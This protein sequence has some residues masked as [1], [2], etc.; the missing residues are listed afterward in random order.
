MITSRWKGP[1]LQP[2]GAPRSSTVFF[3]GMYEK[4]SYV[5]DEVSLK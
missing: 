4:R 5:N 3:G 2:A 1:T